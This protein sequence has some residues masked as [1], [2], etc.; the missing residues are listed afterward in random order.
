MDE[1]PLKIKTTTLPINIPSKNM[2]SEQYSLNNMR[3]D[4]IKN[5]PPTQW[6]IRLNKR[7]GDSPIKHT[8]HN[9]KPLCA[10]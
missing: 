9:N 5:S 4:P 3:F 2:S 10:Q 7:V 6:K 1:M 8:L